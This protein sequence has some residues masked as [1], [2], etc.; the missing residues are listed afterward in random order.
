M[1]YPHKNQTSKT[2]MHGKQNFN[3]KCVKHVLAMPILITS[4][5]RKLELNIVTLVIFLFSLGARAL[6]VYKIII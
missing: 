6:H 4:R 1:L 2:R 3:E 5:L